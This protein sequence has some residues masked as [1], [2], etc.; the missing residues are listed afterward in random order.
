MD[1]SHRYNLIRILRERGREFLNPEEK[2]RFFQYTVFVAIGVSTMFVF[3][4][5]DWIM[6]RYYLCATIVAS[7][8]ALIYGWYL[9]FKGRA[10]RF[11]YRGNCLLFTG[12]VLYLMFLGGEENSMLLWVFVTPLIV[13]YLLGRTEGVLGTIFIWGM[14]ALFFFGPVRFQA[15]E[16]Y[17][18]IFAIRLLIVYAIVSLLTYTFENFRYLYRVNLEEKNRALH[19]EIHERHRVEKSLVESELRYRVIYLQAAEG[20]LLIENTGIIVE[21]NPQIQQMLGYAEK[22]LLGRNVFSFINKEDLERTP[23]QLPKMLAGETILLER[24]LKTVTGDLLVCEQS[25]KMIGE[26]LIILLYRDITER[27]IAEIA[28]E[29]ANRA[30]DKLAHLDGLTQVANRRKFDACLENEWQRMSRE[31]KGI[32]LILGDLDFFKQYNDVYGHQAGDDCLVTVASVLS[33]LVHRPADLVARYGGEEF[34]ILLPDTSYQGCLSVAERMRGGIEG[35]DLNHSGSSCSSVV[36]MSFGVATST[37]SEVPDKTVLVS[38][39]DKALYE[40]KQQG[41]NKVC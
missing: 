6:G 38:S 32:G 28:L 21:C 34:V 30:L 40:A 20:I 17:S 18:D 5:Y 35:L 31:T 10:Q 9:V 24:Q 22:D 27:K 33:G 13:F 26:N 23:S 39:A 3:T 36:T 11:V 16:G 1:K 37:P 41:R 4:L 12:L 19:D 14:L 15:R 29:R 8:I 2:T 25:G 7:M